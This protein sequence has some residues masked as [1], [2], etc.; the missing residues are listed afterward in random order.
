MGDDSRQLASLARAWDD[1][2][3]EYERYFVPRFAPWVDAAVQEVTEV[4]LPPG[5]VVVPCCGTFPELPALTAALPG[6][7]I[8]GIDLSPGMVE[9]ARRRAAGLPHV[10]LVVGDAADLAPEWTAVCAGVVSVFGLQQLP[11]PEAA[12]GAWV[13]ALRPEGRLSVMYW[14]DTLEDDGP[15]AVL[16]RVLSGARPRAGDAWGGTGSPTWSV[17]AER[18]SSETSIRP[19]P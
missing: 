2:A 15:F 7:D 18:R 11:D 1:A 16:D 12:L 8:A 6:R 3:S 14:P 5:P 9:I 13:S 4:V 10:R 19:S 17:P